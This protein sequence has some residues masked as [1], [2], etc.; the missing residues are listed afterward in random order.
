MIFKSDCGSG[1][2]AVP[3]TVILSF[4]ISACVVGPIV[5]ICNKLETWYTYNINYQTNIFVSTFREIIFNQSFDLKIN[6]I[7]Q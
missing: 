7:K 2:V 6:K 4:S 1:L 3:K 5:I